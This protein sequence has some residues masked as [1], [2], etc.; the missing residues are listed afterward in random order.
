MHAW[1][2]KGIDGRRR[3][4]L[5]FAVFAYDFVREG[6]EQLRMRGPQNLPHAALMRWVG[7]TM[8]ET[9]RDRLDLLRAECGAEP[10]DLSVIKWRKHRAA[11][12]D[13]LGELECEL[14]WDQRFRP[15]EKEIEGLDAVAAT[16]RIGIAEAA[17]SDERCACAL[18]L[19]HRV[20]GDGGAVQHLV[21]CRHAA[22][23]ERKAVGHSAG[24]I[25]G[26]GRGLRR[27]NA[28][29]NAADQVGKGAANVDADNVHP[30]SFSLSSARSALL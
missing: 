22:M 18:P 25:G 3:S 2:D 26:Y 11:G 1:P 20:N 9:Y 5:V 10:F 8:Q 19:Q 28:A 7:V 6:H 27:D 30:V 12:I 4:A 14:A 13:P 29:V 17:G 16:D 21:E 23:R 15:M 24:R